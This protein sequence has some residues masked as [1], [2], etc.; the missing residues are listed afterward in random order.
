MRVL[1]WEGW[2]GEEE[3]KDGAGEKEDGCSREQEAVG[4]GRLR[5]VREEGR[6]EEKAEEQRREPL[7]LRGGGKGDEVGRSRGQ[8]N[9]S[10]IPEGKTLESGDAPRGWGSVAPRLT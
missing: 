10:G 6:G 7:T 4:G 1:R 8:T 3:V 2:G 9:E 5:G